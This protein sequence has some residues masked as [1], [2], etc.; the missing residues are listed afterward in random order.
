ME[1][2]SQSEKYI[3]RAVIFF[4][5]LKT[6]APRL[7][8]FSVILKAINTHARA[9]HAQELVC[10]KCRYLQHMVGHVKFPTQN[11]HILRFLFTLNWETAPNQRLF[12][13][14]CFPFKNSL[15]KS[16]LVKVRS[17]LLRRNRH[18]FYLL[19]PLHCTG[20]F[21]KHLATWNSEYKWWLHKE[22]NKHK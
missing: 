19:S 20:T 6:A 18:A 5:P 7:N 4:F 22:G 14:V 2:S 3:D 9:N 8:D 11:P 10:S 12:L 15:E 21:L 16:S 17:K 13:F 1:C